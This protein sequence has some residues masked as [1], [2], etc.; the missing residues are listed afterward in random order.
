MRVRVRAF[1]W[2]ANLGI[3]VNN[4]LKIDR[5]VSVMFTVRAQCLSRLR[6]DQI[7]LFMRD[8]NLFQL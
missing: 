2:F 5:G 7:T 8:N 4:L 1:V 3:K 6:G